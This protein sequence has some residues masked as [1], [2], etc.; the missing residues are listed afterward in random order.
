MM[1]G[2]IFLFEGCVGGLALGGT[3]EQQQQTTTRKKASK[4]KKWN[5]ISFRNE[6]LSARF[7]QKGECCSGKT[8]SKIN[9]GSDVNVVVVVE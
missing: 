8:L 3:R 7:Y 9:G 2:F 1:M 5:K 4:K 6:R